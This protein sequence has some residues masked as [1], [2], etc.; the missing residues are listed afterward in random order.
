MEKVCKDC[1]ASKPL[2]EFYK[3][4]SM[5]DGHLNSCKSC[6]DERLIRLPC[7]VCGSDF[8][9]VHHTD[10]TAPL[11]V[12]W[13]CNEHHHE[14]HNLEARCRRREKLMSKNG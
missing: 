7:M 9:E 13:L 4:R 3:H 11:D 14:V 1:G 12:I 5:S 6:R 10:Y 2:N 8:A